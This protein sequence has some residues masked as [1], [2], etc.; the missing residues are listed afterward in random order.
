MH[1]RALPAVLFLLALVSIP[2]S[3]GCGG[4]DIRAPFPDV[5]VNDRSAD[6]LE[7]APLEE[8]TAGGDTA[9]DGAG[10]DAA[11]P[12]A[13]ASLSAGG[14]PP[15]LFVVGE[16]T[17]IPGATPTLRVTAPTSGATIR[18]GAVTVRFQLR[19]WELASPAGPHV[20]LILDNEPYVAI[21]DAA[22]PVDL[23][24]VV[25]HPIAEGTHVL[26]LFP[27]RGHHE[28]VKDAGAFAVVVFHYGHATE[29]FAFDPSAPLLT[30]SRPK[31]CN[32]LGE[33][34]LVDFFV[35]NATLAP[36]GHHVRWTLDGRTGDITSWAPHW[37]EGLAA[38]SHELRLVLV[39]PDGAPV[40]GMFNDTTRSFT[41]A[42]SCS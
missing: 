9:T 23:A 20:H 39:G 21:R 33:R 32:V 25:G 37:I 18:S 24:A 28:S 27:S 41:V 14:P 17:P 2:L 30:Y 13:D 12:E 19:D 35:S 40:P 38:G 5:T 1:R 6:D 36:A 26:R 29:G 22:A 34:V 16:T 31:G 10:A 11:P 7:L 3:L 42:A 8:A 15:P 4:S